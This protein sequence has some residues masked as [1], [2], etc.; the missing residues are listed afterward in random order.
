MSTRT[1]SASPDR[2]TRPTASSWVR[3]PDG[4]RSVD[5]PWVWRGFLFLA[6]IGFGILLACLSLGLTVYAVAW[7][8][9]TASWLTVATWLWVRHVR[10]DDR[11]VRMTARRRT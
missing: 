6:L 9:I 4:S 1:N 11:A 8:V 7:G 2:V 3:L 10:A 5:S